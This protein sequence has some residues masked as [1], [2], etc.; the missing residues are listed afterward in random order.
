MRD[1]SE[2][3]AERIPRKLDRAVQAALHAQIAQDAQAQ[4]LG[5]DARRQSARQRDAHRVGHAHPQFAR[6]P[7]R[8]HLRPPDP[9]PERAQ[10]A[11]MRGVAVRAQDRLAGQD[12]RFFAEHLMADAAPDF[13]EMSDALL[14]HPRADLGVVLRVFASSAR[15][16]HDPA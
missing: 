15:A 9:G 7:Q 10:P 11:K 8:R 6:G 13:E 3:E 16:R 12:Q 4:I 14:A 2:S 5:C 1:A